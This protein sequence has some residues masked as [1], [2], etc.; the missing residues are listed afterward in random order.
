MQARLI[1]GFPGYRATERGVIQSAWKRVGARYGSWVISSEWT[2]M[3]AKVSSLTCKYLQ[4]GLKDSGGIQ[5]K[6][7]LHLFV[8]LAWYGPT[9]V[10]LE[11]AHED[12][13]RFN[14]RPDNLSF[15]TRSE[16]AK[17]RVKHQRQ[18]KLQLL[19]AEQ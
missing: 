6:R 3:V 9:P 5:R 18:R 16:N 15:K 17:D 10:G 1:P 7:P 12:G 13:D 2:D 19:T 4:L 14:C 11:V 8:A